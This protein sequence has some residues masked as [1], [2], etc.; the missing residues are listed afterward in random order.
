MDA[1]EQRELVAVRLAPQ[2][3]QQLER[4][5]IANDRSISAEASRIVRVFL[6]RETRHL[7]R[8]VF[9]L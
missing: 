9:D 6:E 7:D 5:A 1:K 2:V 3:K 4:L 8:E